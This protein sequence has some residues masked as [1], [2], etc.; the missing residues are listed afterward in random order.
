M[1]CHSRQPGC[2]T[3]AQGARCGIR[4]RV[5]VLLCLLAF[6]LQ[7]TVQ[8]VH[9]WEVATEG[10]V[11]ASDPPAVPL[12]LGSVQRPT[13]LSATDHVLQRVPHNHAVCSVCQTL[14]RLQVYMARQ[15][16]ATGLSA[17]GAWFVLSRTARVFNLPLSAAAPRAPPFLS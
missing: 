9:M 2:A 13:A 6:A 3:G 15:S 1:G 4:S 11:V 10:G 8:A 5:S 17:T 14:S 16:W 7:F 12:L